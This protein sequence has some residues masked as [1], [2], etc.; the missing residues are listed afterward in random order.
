[1]PHGYVAALRGFLLMFLVTMPFTMIGSFHGFAIFG[2]A[3]I[4]YI[5]L[6]LVRRSPHTMP[7]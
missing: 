5:F 7:L 1:M 2:E 6:D 3:L 4:A